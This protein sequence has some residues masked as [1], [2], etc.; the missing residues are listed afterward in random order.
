[1]KLPLEEY[2]GVVAAEMPVDFETEALLQAVAARTY[3]IKRYEA[4]KKNPNKDH[5][6]A[7]ICTNHAHCQAYVSK[8]E[9]S[10]TGYAKYPGYYNKIARPSMLQPVVLVY[11]GKL[12][13]PV[14]H[15]TSVGKPKIRET[16]GSLIYH[17]KV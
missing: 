14:Y 8:D 1:M 16:F 4:A 13:D 2:I 3:T 10:K 17:L 7:H 12:I 6:D 5:P 11:Q 15:S 9:M